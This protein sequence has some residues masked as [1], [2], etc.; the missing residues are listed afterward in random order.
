MSNMLA[1]QAFT[2]LVK[3]LPS[4]KNDPQNLDQRLDLLLGAYLG[5]VIQMNSG[6]GVAAAISYQVERVL[7]G[8]PWDRRRHLRRR[9]GEVQHRCRLL[10][11]RAE[12]APL[13]GVGKRWREQESATM[14]LPC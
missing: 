10:P 2:L 14:P 7:Q 4:L 11:V 12:L 1:R 6:S 8:A 13:I 5:G 9:H 3:A